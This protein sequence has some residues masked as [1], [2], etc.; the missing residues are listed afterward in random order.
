M[1]CITAGLRVRIATG[2]EEDTAGKMPTSEISLIKKKPN[3]DRFDPLASHWFP[4]ERS[5]GCLMLEQ[6]ASE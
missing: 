3:I 5:F 4:L 1:F 2:S 6:I